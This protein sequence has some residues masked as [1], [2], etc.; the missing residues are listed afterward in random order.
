MSGKEHQRNVLQFAAF[1]CNWNDCCQGSDKEG[2]GRGVGGV[3]SCHSQA[4]APTNPS[5]VRSEGVISHQRK[6]MAKDTGGCVCE[7]L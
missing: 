7:Y 6:Y 2:R 4:N 1:A 3:A 5:T